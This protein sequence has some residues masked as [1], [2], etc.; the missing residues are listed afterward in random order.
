MQINVGHLYSLY[1]WKLFWLNIVIKFADYLVENYFGSLQICHDDTPK[2]YESN[3]DFYDSSSLTWHSIDNEKQT[4]SKLDK[5]SRRFE[6]DSQTKPL[7]K[8][9]QDHFSF[10]NDLIEEAIT[11][12]R[13]V[14]V[15]RNKK[16]MVQQKT[17]NGISMT[18]ALGLNSGVRI[19]KMLKNEDNFGATSCTIGKEKTIVV[20]DLGLEDMVL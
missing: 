6:F 7:E 16:Q 2:R 20:S 8:G 15:R 11:H 19:E 5:R 14:I 10:E 17:A 3:F 1:F 13:E 12:G 4:L 18:A 9:I